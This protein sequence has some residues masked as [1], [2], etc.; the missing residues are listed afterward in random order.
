M[1]AV[2]LGIIGFGIMGERLLRAALED[3]S[4]ELEVI[5][6]WD[7]A[8]AAQ[9]RLRASLPEVACLESAET[10]V[11]AADCVYI[12]SPPETHLGYARAALAAGKAVFSEKPL[13][14]NLAD[15]AKFVEE[16]ERDMGRAAVNFIFAS[17]P[18]VDHLKD[19]LRAG[20][21]GTPQ[22]IEIEVGFANWPRPWQMDAAGWLERR[23]QGGFSREV[24]SHF[25][26]LTQRLGGDLVLNEHRVRFPDGD[27]AETGLDAQL[28][29]GGLPVSLSGAVG[30]TEL[31]EFNHWTLTGS[32]G[33]IRLRDWAVAEELDSDG[34]WQPASDAMPNE[35][36]RPLVLRRQLAKLVKLT[37]G[38]DQDLA[39]VAEAFAVQ[40]IVEALL[41]E[42]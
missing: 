31:A 25:L 32:A 42:N 17:S 41:Q 40:R 37:Q 38:Q 19:W 15:A 18:A 11:E 5:G 9:E 12:A 35:K 24:I 4:G 23:A 6:V 26:F 34:L 13:A 14:V 33:A 20:L 36:A 1:T 29:A 21:I 7:P 22:S 8:E 28:T 2:K 39:T 10:V 27:G 16:V 30:R 3:P